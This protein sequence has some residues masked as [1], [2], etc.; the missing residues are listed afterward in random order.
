[1]KTGTIL[2]HKYFNGVIPEDRSSKYRKKASE[3]FNDF[4]MY[5]TG[6][7]RMVA[8]GPDIEMDYNWRNI[9]LLVDYAIQN[10]SNIHY[11]TVITGHLDVFPDWYK[12]LDSEKKYAALEKHVRAVI[13]RCR[14]KISFFKLVNEVVR[15][16]DKDFLGTG[17]KKAEAI[18]DIFKWAT[19]EYPEGRYM[20]NEY[21]C[22]VRDEIRGAFLKL[23]HDIKKLGAR[24]DIIGEQAHSGYH[25][26]PFFLPP[27]EQLKGVL[28]EI[29]E[30]TE[31]PLMITEFDMGPKNGDYE[32]GSIDPNEP[33]EDENGTYSS[34]YE[35]QGFAYEHFKQLCE[36]TGYVEEF[37][38]WSLVDDPSI[39]WER[40]G[41][42][43]LNE[44][45]VEKAWTKSLLE[46]ISNEKEISKRSET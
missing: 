30:R 29:Y 21:G 37:Y 28:D 3:Y 23:V 10:N 4:G 33:V 31:L 16:Q 34:W 14:G 40:N 32:G 8:R 9:D 36:D 45:F 26:R 6:I 43:L 15:E 44:D 27:D 20:L 13:N 38:Y 18:A 25:P 35:Y 11:N 22:L 12:G 7:F 46:Q 2:H 41:C 17:R 5:G 42:G 1:M 19:E 24:I 39:T